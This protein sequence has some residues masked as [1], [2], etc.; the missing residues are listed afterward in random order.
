[1]KEILDLFKWYT[2]DKIMSYTLDG[3]SFYI[4]PVS[5]INRIR[6]LPREEGFY[7]LLFYLIVLITLFFLSI[8]NGNLFRATQASLILSLIQLPI[9]ILP[10]AI[11]LYIT[12]RIYKIETTLKITFSEACLFLICCNIFLAPIYI[13]IITVFEKTEAYQFLLLSNLFLAI[14]VFFRLII[15]SKVYFVRIKHILT[16]LSITAL[17]YNLEI[18]LLFSVAHTIDKESL[19]KLNF[20]SAQSSD[21]IAYELSSIEDKLEPIKFNEVPVFVCYLVEN[22]KPAYYWFTFSNSKLSFGSVVSDMGKNSLLT[23]SCIMSYKKCRYILSKSTDSIRFKRNKEYINNLDAYYKYVLTFVDSVKDV[24]NLS[25]TIRFIYS[26]GKRKE[27]FYV[28][29]FDESQDKM[30]QLL[31]ARINMYEA[32]YNAFIP[33]YIVGFYFYPSIYFI[34]KTYPQYVK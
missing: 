6:T 11:S 8:T 33:L 7:K 16:S 30:T 19:L 1:M 2:P 13:L 29:H 5:F 28:R 31:I 10:L 25:D 26:P 3:I 27:G 14:Y 17:L 22:K 21:A 34:E 24:Q 23:D 12:K 20:K 18:I 9:D 4:K 32:S 15:I